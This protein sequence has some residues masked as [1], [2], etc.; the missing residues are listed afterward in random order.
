MIDRSNSRRPPKHALVFDP[1]GRDFAPPFS[2][3]KRPTLFAPPDEI[4]LASPLTVNG[5]AHQHGVDIVRVKG[6]LS[7][8]HPFDGQRF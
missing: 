7:S 2:A 4:N 6:V 5:V 1:P 8:P 3:E